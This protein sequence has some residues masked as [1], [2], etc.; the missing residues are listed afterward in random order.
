MQKIISLFKR[1]YEGTR[2]VY[3]EVVPGADWVIAG[4]GVATVK[5]DGTACLV[6]DGRLYKRY[7][8]KRGRTPPAGFEPAQAEALID[9]GHGIAAHLAGADGV[10]DRGADVAGGAREIM[11][12]PAAGRIVDRDA[13]ARNQLTTEPR[14]HESERSSR[15][16]DS[17]REVAGIPGIA[18][19]EPPRHGEEADHDDV[20]QAMDCADAT[21]ARSLWNLEPVE[22]AEQCR[23]QQQNA[24]ADED[25][26]ANHRGVYIAISLTVKMMA[27]SLPLRFRA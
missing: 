17:D 21:G 4:E 15:Q 6:K 16:L 23:G 5:F 18:S 7:D 1:D 27:S 2:L 10:E 24:A 13:E 11:T 20:P 9:H 22:Q 14:C 26:V 19:A 12:S 3:D 25:V 8:A